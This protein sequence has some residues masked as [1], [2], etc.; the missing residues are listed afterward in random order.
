MGKRLNQPQRFDPPYGV[1]PRR[2]PGYSLDVGVLLILFLLLGFF[3]RN[4]AWMLLVVPVWIAVRVAS[5]PRHLK[6]LGLWPE[7]AA[8]AGHDKSVA[9]QPEP[10]QFSLLQ[11]LLFVAGCAAIW[12]AV[13]SVQPPGPDGYPGKIIG[14]VCGSVL[15]GG[16]FLTRS[17]QRRRILAEILGAAAGIC[18]G[19]C[20]LSPV[21]FS[22]SFGYDFGLGEERM[23][24]F[25][26]A[27]LSAIAGATAGYVLVERKRRP[28]A[29]GRQVAWA[30]SRGR[31]GVRNPFA[32]PRQGQACHP[33]PFSR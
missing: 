27:C 19:G 8:D 7:P 21:V 32:C 20:C 9:L 12:G 31:A 16:V 23:S 15:S 4:M 24:L 18:F 25:I 13:S 3:G 14:F 10:R 33:I 1:P 26:G 5:L 29:L 22:S 17:G 2:W 11:L 30:P 28:A 6:E